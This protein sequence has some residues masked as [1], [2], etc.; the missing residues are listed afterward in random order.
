VCYIRS[1]PTAGVLAP[2]QSARHGRSLHHKARWHAIFEQLNRG[3]QWQLRVHS[4]QQVRQ[5]QCQG[6]AERE[7]ED[8]S[9]DQAGQSGDA[10]RLVCYIQVHGQGRHRPHAHHRLAQGRTSHFL[11]RFVPSPDFSCFTS[12]LL[13]FSQSEKSQPHTIRSRN[14]CLFSDLLIKFILS[15]IDAVFSKLDSVNQFNLINQDISEQRPNAAKLFIGSGKKKKKKT[16][17]EVIKRDARELNYIISLNLC[18]LLF[19]F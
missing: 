13:I 6:H 19:E 11:C 9:A 2:Q 16:Q 18:A 5:R 17:H 10:R 7:A 8:N 14:F 15:Q 3:R 4:N 12:Y 1:A